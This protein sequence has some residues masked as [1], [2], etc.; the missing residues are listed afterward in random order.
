MGAVKT[1]KADS[2]AL[3]E[4]LGLEIEH[5]PVETLVPY[6]R[7]ARTHSDEQVALI[8]GS[9]R[10]FGFTDPVLVDGANGVIARHG[11]G[12]GGAQARAGDRAGDR[13]R[14]PD[15]GAETSAGA[16]RQPAGRAGG[17]GPRAAGARGGRAL[18]ARCRSRRARHRGRRDRSAA[19]RRRRGRRSRRGAADDHRARAA[20]QP[21]LA[22]GRPLAARQPP[23]AVRRRHE[24][25]R[26][27]PAD[28]RRAR[29]PVRDRPALSGR[30]QWLE[31]SDPEQ[32]LVRVLRDDVGRQQPGRRALRRLHQRRGNQRRSSRTRPGTAGMRAAARR[33]S[34]S[35]GSGP[36]PSCTSRSSG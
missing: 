25:G 24:P 28:E 15:G 14:A 9:I 7:N 13:A 10:E 32:G 5:R 23:P 30:L 33:C 2:K 4:G 34:K 26:C 1:Q 12:D 8:A 20:A 22:H 6:A 27:A 11:R 18:D 16:G 3:Q 31:P 17:L 19:A 29:D 21:G 35:A 36:T